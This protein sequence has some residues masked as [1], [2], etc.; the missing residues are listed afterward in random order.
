MEFV[1]GE[2][3]I[4]SLK[5]LKKGQLFGNFIFYI[6]SRASLSVVR[7]SGFSRTLQKP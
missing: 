3:E 6:S 1:K 7:E 2:Y 5:L 4:I